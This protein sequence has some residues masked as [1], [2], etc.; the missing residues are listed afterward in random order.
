MDDQLSEKFN[1][2]VRNRCFFRVDKPYPRI[3]HTEVLK[4]IVTQRFTLTSEL[5]HFCKFRVS[6]F[7]TS[8]FAWSKKINFDGKTSL[9]S[10]PPRHYFLRFF[11]LALRK[12][13]EK[14]SSRGRILGSLPKPALLP[15]YYSAENCFAVKIEWM[16]L[17][18]EKR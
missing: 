18:R 10:Y 5:V 16:C 6:E 7:Q 12:R 9:I 3:N 1:A 8:G 15:L 17:V 4:S 11:T 14:R 13:P 2:R